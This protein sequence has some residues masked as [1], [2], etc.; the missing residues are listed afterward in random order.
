MFLELVNVFNK[1][2]YIIVSLFSSQG[3][4][5]VVVTNM[6]L[7]IIICNRHTIYAMI[8]PLAILIF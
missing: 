4:L 5:E 2:N 8:S 1:D 6:L 3:R 7:L